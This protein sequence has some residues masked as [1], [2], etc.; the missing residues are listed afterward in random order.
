VKLVPLTAAVIPTRVVTVTEVVVTVKVPDVWP[1]AI[2]TVAG[3][4]PAALLE[5]RLRT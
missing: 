5:D 4:V 1:A 3:G 2:V